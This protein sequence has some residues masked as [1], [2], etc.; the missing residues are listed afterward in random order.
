MVAIITCITGLATLLTDS[1]IWAWGE[2]SFTFSQLGDS[3]RGICL[4]GSGG[5]VGGRVTAPVTNLTWY[6]EVGVRCALARTWFT[7]YPADIPGCLHKCKLSGEDFVSRRSFLVIWN[8][9]VQN[10]KSTPW[11]LS[12]HLLPQNDDL[13]RKGERYTQVF[14]NIYCHTDFQGCPL[15]LQQDNAKTHF[16]HVTTARL[17]SKVYPQ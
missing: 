6:F 13:W 16:A 3:N 7:R 9:Q 17:C 1:I 4:L 5:E 2:G 15:F 14:S 12:W 10:V 11:K 8:V